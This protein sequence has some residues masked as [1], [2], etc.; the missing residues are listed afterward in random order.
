M[1]SPPQLSRHCHTY[2]SPAVGCATGRNRKP[3]DV[4][5]RQHH[6]RRPRD[7]R[8]RCRCKRRHSRDSNP[9]EKLPATASSP[10]PPSMSPTARKASSV[11]LCT[12]LACVREPFNQLRY[13]QQTP[14]DNGGIPSRFR[15]SSCEAIKPCSNA[16]RP[17]P[18]WS[19]TLPPSPAR[20]RQRIINVKTQPKSI[21]SASGSRD[22][23]AAV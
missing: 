13:S 2:R 15:P 10:L 16:K 21:A 5:L 22:L 14:A 9:D 20:I 6:Q 8:P 1:V 19:P 12:A 17:N 3:A 11:R 23:L 4:Q 18:R 7:Y